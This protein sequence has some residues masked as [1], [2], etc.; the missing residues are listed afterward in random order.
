[1]KA[2]IF[3]LAIVLVFAISPV[4]AQIVSNNNS[5]NNN[6]PSKIITR[7][8]STHAIQIHD[9]NDARIIHL[10]GRDM[11]ISMLAI[12]QLGLISQKL[13]MML[14]DTKTQ[15]VTMRTSKAK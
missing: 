15:N 11:T 5:N 3:S 7:V 10:I 13:F 1:M 2:I 4:T 9:P 12:W 8:R 14:P 6:D